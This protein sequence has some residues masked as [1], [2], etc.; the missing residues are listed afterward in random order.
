MIHD[1]TILARKLAYEGK[2]KDIA[3]VL[4][5]AECL[6]MLMF[7]AKDCTTAFRHQLLVLATRSPRFLSRT[8]AMRLVGVAARPHFQVK[9]CSTHTP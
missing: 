7:D 4:D 1:S 5:K 9:A 8:G 2:G 3:E 6:P